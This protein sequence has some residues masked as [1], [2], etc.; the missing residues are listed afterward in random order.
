MMYEVELMNLMF[1]L[2]EALQV[3]LMTGGLLMLL[4][5]FFRKKLHIENYFTEK[6]FAYFEKVDRT[7]K[8]ILF[9]WRRKERQKERQTRRKKR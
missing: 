3:A 1:K 6:G 5:W 9:V 7:V 8:S 4:A 2:L